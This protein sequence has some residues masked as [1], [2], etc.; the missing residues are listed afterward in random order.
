MYIPTIAIIPT[1]HSIY[2]N[3][4]YHTVYEHWTLRVEEIGDLLLLQPFIHPSIVS[5]SVTVPPSHS[6]SQC[7]SHWL[8]RTNERTNERTTPR[9][10]ERT[11]ERTNGTTPRTAGDAVKLRCSSQFAGPRS[12]S[13]V[14]TSLT[15]LSVPTT[16]QQQRKQQRCSRHRS[17][18]AD[19]A[20]TAWWERLD[21]VRAYER[22]YVRT[23]A[24]VNRAVVVAAQTALLEP[25]ASIKP[26]G[27]YL[28]VTVE[29]TRLIAS[30]VPWLV[31]AFVR[32]WILLAWLPWTN[33]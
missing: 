30:L 17:R 14:V 11:N 16:Q 13:F 31:G 21:C 25:G 32:W 7:H 26:S 24:R 12:R 6:Q 2:A 19:T 15:V 20:Q 27:R 18:E 10:N 29:D 22:T 5:H 1:L 23:T 3:T 9:T 28:C 33:G 4:E 8:Q